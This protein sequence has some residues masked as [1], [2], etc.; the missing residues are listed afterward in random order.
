[1]T[2]E[3]CQRGAR[4]QTQCVQVCVLALQRPG[5]TVS[6]TPVNRTKLHSPSGHRN[7][8]SCQALASR[9]RAACRLRCARWRIALVTV[10]RARLSFASSL[11]ESETEQCLLLVNEAAFRTASEELN[12]FVTAVLAQL[13]RDE[14]GHHKWWHHVDRQSK[15][16]APHRR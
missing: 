16:I 9:A 5:L 3:G 2:W 13:R 4:T 1:M 11:R 6:V 14:L 15:A 12:D 8:T 7:H 10:E